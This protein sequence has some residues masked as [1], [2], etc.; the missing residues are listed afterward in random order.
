MKYETPINKYNTIKKIGEGTYGEVLHVSTSKKHQNYALKMS[1]KKEIYKSKN[2]KESLILKRLKHNNIIKIIDTINDNDNYGIILPLYKMN[3]Y[4]YIKKQI[5]INH[6]DTCIILLKI[7]SGL[8]YL[9]RNS[10]IHRDLKPENILLNSLNDIVIS[11][12]G[13]S[14][15]KRYLECDDIP[16]KVQ[17]VYYR[18]PEIFL[19]SPYNE[20]IDI[21]SLGCIAY[22]IYWKRPLFTKKDPVELFI[23]QNVILKPPP[24]SFLRNYY[25]TYPLYD[26]IENPSYM[27]L[28][29]H[30]IP[31]SSNYLNIAH[32]KNKYIIDFVK[33]CC[34]WIPSN[35]ITPHES[36]KYLKNV[37]KKS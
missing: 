33:R 9:K 13:I 3:L 29:S 25:I 8:D 19:R 12:F 10:V 23:E 31:L 30:K 18:S 28:N 22:E 4:Q 27:I 36:V 32:N 15:E 35:R 21:W 7:S 11:D 14:I 34:E 24:E 37:Q 16:Y 6:H 5:Y 2:I 26:D 1:R 20:S 17:T